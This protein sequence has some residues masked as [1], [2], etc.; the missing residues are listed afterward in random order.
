MARDP[1]REDAFTRALRSPCDR[2]G[3]IALLLRLRRA[4][5]GG[6][7]RL[8]VRHGFS[9]LLPHATSSWRRCA[10]GIGVS[11]V[12][13]RICRFKLFHR[14][15]FAIRFMVVAEQMQIAMHGKM[16]RDDARTACVRARLRARPSRRRSRCRRDAW[17]HAAPACRRGKGQ[18]VGRLVLPRH[19]ALSACDGRV[20]GE[21]D[22]NLRAL[23]R[24]RPVPRSRWRGAR[25][26][27]RPDVRSRDGIDHR[28]R[29]SDRIGS[30]S[31][32]AAVIPAPLAFSRRRRGII[33]GDD[34][35]H[36]F[37]ADD[38]FVA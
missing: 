37:V 8:G 10:I 16:R 35:R 27:R 31:R 7:R 24:R 21:H 6:R 26:P 20:V 33:G 15:G 29:S 34:P 4:L 18:H 23:A 17:P 14:L 13:A 9:T 11:R 2:D 1:A 30:L 28:R 3:Q 19:R 36:E 38:V 12:R 32:R 22:R 5:G 25:Y